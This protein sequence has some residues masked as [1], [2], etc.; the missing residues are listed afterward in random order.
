MPI[1]RTDL[2]TR[3]NF[4]KIRVLLVYHGTYATATATRNGQRCRIF[5]NEKGQRVG[6]SIISL[7]VA[8]SIER[9]LDNSGFVCI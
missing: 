1:Q 9:Q 5:R 7:K 8:D 3:A 2:S 6:Y 4:G